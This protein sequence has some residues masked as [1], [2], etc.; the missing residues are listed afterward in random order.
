MKYEL[1][2][3]DQ[4]RIAINESRPI[5][6]PLGVIEYHGEHCAVGTDIL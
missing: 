3:P 6:L 1:M 2:F 4:I 5:I